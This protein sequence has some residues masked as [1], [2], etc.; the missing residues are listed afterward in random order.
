MIGMTE[1]LLALCLTRPLNLLENG[2][3]L[4]LTR[5]RCILRFIR[6]Q[7]EIG[8][9]ETRTQIPHDADTVYLHTVPAF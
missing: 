3:G 9:A 2:F 8:E 6:G 5:Y 4:Q 7:K 1:L